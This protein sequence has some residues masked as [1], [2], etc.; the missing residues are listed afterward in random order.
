MDAVPAATPGA[1]TVV[2]QDPTGP[3]QIILD[4][5]DG[6]TALDGNGGTVTLMPGT[7]GVVAPLAPSGVP[8]ATQGFT[9]SGLTLTPSLLRPRPP[10]YGCQQHRG[11]GVGQSHHRH[12]RQSAAGR[13]ISAS[14][15][16]TIY[17]FTANY[18]GGNGNDLVLT[19]TVGGLQPQT[20]AFGSIPNHSYGNTFRLGHRVLEAAGELLD[21]FGSGGHQ[22]R[23]SDGC[24][25]RPNHGPGEPERRHRLFARPC[26]G[27]NIRCRPR[28]ID[29]HRQPADENLRGDPAGAD[30]KLHGPG[31]RRHAGQSDGAADDYHVGNGRKPGGDL[32]DQVLVRSIRIKDLLFG[33]QPESPARR[34]EV[35]FA[36]SLGPVVPGHPVVFKATVAVVAP[37]A[38]TPA[39]TVVSR[40]QGRDY[41]GRTIGTTGTASLSTSFSTAGQ[42][43]YG[44]LWGRRDP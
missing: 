5:S 6:G 26:G 41:R 43:R 35:A 36:A 23:Q 25:H 3:G 22:R 18:A 11:A 39:G 31:Q 7:G 12:I 40:G 37:G 9:A 21:P 32:Y 28:P 33:R 29:D 24:R 10:L 13:T 19:N 44:R 27:G 38:G 2:V 30:G 20:I 16:G 4:D 1:A 14:Y 42:Y 17:Y 8:L 15:D 34:D